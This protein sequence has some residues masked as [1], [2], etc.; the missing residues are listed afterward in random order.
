MPSPEH[1]LRELYSAQAVSDR[2]REIGDR[3]YRDYADTPALFLV[4]A[5]GARRFAETLVNGL[6]ARNV[7]PELL[8]LRARAALAA[9]SDA[10]GAPLTLAKWSRPRLH[11]QAERDARRLARE[12]L[13]LRPA[14]PPS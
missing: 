12:W 9:A 10:A 14:K 4:I 11:K 7:H 3:L 1:T 8:F 5:E 2:I 13:T 6:V